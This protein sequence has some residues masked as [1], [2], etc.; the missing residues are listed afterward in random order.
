VKVRGLNLGI[1][2]KRRET[3]GRNGLGNRTEADGLRLIERPE[4][5]LAQPG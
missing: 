1:T 3:A 5:S 2:I 4:V